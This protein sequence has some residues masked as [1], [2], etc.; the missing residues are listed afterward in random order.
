MNEDSSRSL[1]GLR[2]V[3]VTTNVAGPFTTQILGDLGADVIK[4]ERPQGGDDTRGWGPPFWP[5]GTGVT[6]SSLNRSK[7]SI[8]LDLQDETDRE[9]FGALIDSADVLVENMRPGA[10]ARLGFTAENLKNRNPRLIY[11]R[12][13]GFGSRGPSAMRPGYDPLVQAYSGLMAMNGAPGSGVARIPVSILDKGSAMWLVIGILDALRMRDQTGVGSEVTT[14]LLET[15]L[16]WESNQIA[17]VVADGTTPRQMGSATGGIA[18]YQAFATLD[19]PLVIAAGNDRIWARLCSALDR[20]D[21]IND[22]QYVSN[23]DRVKNRDKLVVEI[24]SALRVRSAQDWEAKLASVGVPCSVVRRVDAVAEDPL[25]TELGLLVD[26]SGLDTG[27]QVGISL[28]LEFDGQRVPV[29][30]T[31]PR[32]DQDG[33]EIRRLIEDA[34]EDI[35]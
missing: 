1:V 5:D 13:T 18:P 19:E 2:V 29:G 14:S 20:S 26:Q 25:L 35:A 3:D 15:A 4:V 34:S 33:V 17:G 24:E 32:L 10:F 8:G 11:A 31:P 9:V 28:P 21:L 30:R 7:R 23:A 16:T 27:P 22:P 6:F 12:I